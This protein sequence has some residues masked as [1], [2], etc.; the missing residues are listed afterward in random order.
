M[1]DR[2][3]CYVQVVILRNMSPKVVWPSIEQ[4]LY[5]KECDPQ[6]VWSSLECLTHG[7]PQQVGVNIY[8]VLCVGLKTKQRQ[9]GGAGC[10]SGAVL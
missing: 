9:I 6:V 8:Q 7:C 3:A 5:K 2:V 4:V 1:D 10:V